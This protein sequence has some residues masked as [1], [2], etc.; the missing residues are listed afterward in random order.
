MNDRQCRICFD[1]GG[2]FV[3]PC[4]CRG[5][6]AYIHT[7]CLRLYFRHYPDGFCRVCMSRMKWVNPDEFHYGLG[8]VLWGLAL[9]Y[10]STLEPDV[11]FM[12]LLLA[13]GSLLYY[14]SIQSMSVLFG[15]I[16]M[17]FSGCL[18]LL[19]YTLGFQLLVLTSISMLMTVLCL[20]IPFQYLMVTFALTLSMLYSSALVLFALARMTPFIASA[21][22]CALLFVWYLA[23]RARPPQLNV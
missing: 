16:S 21:L 11:R 7:H 5:T 17:I 13:G 4:Q 8:V 1:S 22:S 10:A 14:Y 6:Q 15:M 9:A 2:Q 18:L 3:V 19:P 20:Y 12:Y 23:I